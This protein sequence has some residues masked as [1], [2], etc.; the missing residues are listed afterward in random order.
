[1]LADTLNQ[2]DICPEGVKRAK[3]AVHRSTG[4]SIERVG[5]RVVSDVVRALVDVPEE[6][7]P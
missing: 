1:M 2:N 7:G 5:C 4:K 3:S 6:K